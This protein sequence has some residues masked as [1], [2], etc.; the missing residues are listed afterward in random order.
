MVLRTWHP[1]C[2]HIVQIGTIFYFLPY[3]AV[4]LQQLFNYQKPDHVKNYCRIKNLTEN[5]D[6]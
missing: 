1:A 6:H 5:F 3:I 2:A 4:F